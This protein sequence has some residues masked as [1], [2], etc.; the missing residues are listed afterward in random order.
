[1][2]EPADLYDGP[3]TYTA[4]RRYSADAGSHWFDPPAMR[5]FR[6]RLEGSPYALG[7]FVSSEQ[8]SDSSPRL[9]SVRRLCLDG[10]VE[11]VGDFQQHD[12]LADARRAARL[13]V[14][15]LRGLLD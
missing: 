14:A 9:Y 15:R 1:M 3:M 2:P 10:T 5:F 7:V 11:T 12:T 6:S 13:E 4:M 8:F